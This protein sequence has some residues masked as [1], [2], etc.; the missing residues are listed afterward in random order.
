[1]FST[2]Y[3]RRQEVRFLSHTIRAQKNCHRGRGGG[4]MAVMEDKTAVGAAEQGTVV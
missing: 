1:V 3:G 4:G 2:W